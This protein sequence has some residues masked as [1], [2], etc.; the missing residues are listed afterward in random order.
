MIRGKISFEKMESGAGEQFLLLS[1][2]AKARAKGN[3]MCFSQTPAC[4]KQTLSRGRPDY[5]RQGMLGGPC[6]AEVGLRRKDICF[7]GQ[8]A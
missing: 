8:S 2:R 1:F 7:Y 5:A 4:F 6:F 3:L